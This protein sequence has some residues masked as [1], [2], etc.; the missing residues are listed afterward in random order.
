[1]SIPILQVIEQFLDYAAKEK[2]FS[3]HT[4]DAYKSDLMQFVDFLEEKKAPLSL[5]EAMK[6]VF[7][8]GFLFQLSKDGKK[9]RSVA[10]KVAA[11]KSFSRFCVKRGLLQANPA[12]VIATPK[13][14]KTLPVFL[15]ERQ[16]ERLNSIKADET[17]S[18]RNRAIIEFFYGSGIRLSELY[19][20]NINLI[21]TRRQTVRV[22]GKGR[23]E[24]IVPITSQAIESYNEYIAKRSSGLE[25]EDP[26]F[27]NSKGLR[28]SRR[29][30]ER[31]VEKEL[32][33]VS[34]NKKRSPHVLRHSFATHLLD[35]G[36]DIRAVKELLGHS[37]LSTTQIY[38]HI[39]KEHLLKIYK[40]AHPRASDPSL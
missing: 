16:T 20:L 5:E 38:T 32:S 12:K 22:M 1:M 33:T 6:K 2:G 25:P 35:N 26:V 28:L 14:D 23:K 40:Q 31:I 24:R 34:T 4:V 10:R 21:D 37:S 11:L 9:S 3:G 27:I 36:A 15:T 30:I 19:S 29:Q 18:V 17:E 13:L 39:S 8:R 7:L